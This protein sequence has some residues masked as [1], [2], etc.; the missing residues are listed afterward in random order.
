MKSRPCSWVFRLS[1]ASRVICER[2]FQKPDVP[3]SVSSGEGRLGATTWK[4]ELEAT[5]RQTVLIGT[6]THTSPTFF[7][8]S[9]I[10]K[11]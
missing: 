4:V 2:H 7:R 3:S 5:D 1:R 10:T 8:T 9:Q 11:A 6:R